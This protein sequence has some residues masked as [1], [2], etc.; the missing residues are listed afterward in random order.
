MASQNDSDVFSV[1]IVSLDYYMSSPIP[2]LDSCSSSFLGTNVEEVPVIRIYGATPAGQKTCVHVHGALPYFYVPFPKHLLQSSEEGQAFI[3]TLSGAM[4]KALRNKS[5]SSSKRQHVH[6][7]SL[8]RAKKLYGYH[9]SEDLF[10]KIFIYYP[11]DISRAASLLLDGSILGTS[12]QPYESHIPYLLQFLVDYNLNGMSHLHTSKVKFRSP[13]TYYCNAASSRNKNFDMPATLSSSDKTKIWLPSTVPSSAVW[14]DSTGSL[15]SIDNKCIDLIRRQSICQLE[16][17]TSVEDIINENFKIYTSLSQTSFDVRMVQSLVPI[18]EEEYERSGIHEATKLDDPKRPRADQVLRSFMDGLNYDKPL[19]ELCLE[20]SNFFPSKVHVDGSENVVKYMKPF[21]DIFTKIELAGSHQHDKSRDVCLVGGEEENRNKET[22]SSQSPMRGDLQRLDTEALGLLSWLAS[23]QAEEEMDTGDEL[24]HEAILSPLL[25]GKSYTAALEIAH[26]DYEHASQVECQDILDSVEDILKSERPKEEASTSFQGLILDSVECILMSDGSKE[27]ALSSSR[28][29]LDAVSSGVSIP[30]VDGSFDDNWKTP[31]KGNT[32]EANMSYGEDKAVARSAG[33]G[34]RAGSKNKERKLWGNLPFS[35]SKNEHEASESFCVSSSSCDEMINDGSYNPPF[36]HKEGNQYDDF[37]NENVIENYSEKSGKTSGLC[38]IRDLMRKKRYIRV[39]QVE[40]TVQKNEDMAHGQKQEL[41]PQFPVEEPSI[42]QSVTH[43]NIRGSIACSTIASSNFQGIECFEHH[44]SVFNTVQK[45][46]SPICTGNVQSSTAPSEIIGFKQGLGLNEQS[47][48]SE[49]A[50]NIEAGEL[51]VLETVP[52]QLLESS[53]VKPVGS[54]SYVKRPLSPP[55]IRKCQ[56]NHNENSAGNAAL[57]SHRHKNWN[58]GNIANNYAITSEGGIAQEALLP[59]MCHRNCQQSTCLFD[60]NSR[61]F[62]KEK[63]FQ[64]YIEMAFINRPPSNMHIYEPEESLPAGQANGNIDKRQGMENI[65]PF[66]PRISQDVNLY[67]E[68]VIFSQDFALGIPTHF[69]N[70]G[71]VL[72]LLTHAQS[73]PTLNTVYDW[74]LEEK[75]RCLLE[76]TGASKEGLDSYYDG[77]LNEGTTSCQNSPSPSASGWSQYDSTQSNK[78]KSFPKTENFHPDIGHFSCE[79]K[80]NNIPAKEKVVNEDLRDLSQISGPEKYG[81]SNPTPIS[82]LGFRDPASVGH[83]QQLTMISME[84]QAE[85]RGDLKPNPKFDAINILSLVVREDTSNVCQ[86]YVLLRVI[87]EKLVE[88]NGNGVS[89]CNLFFFTEE[90]LLLEHFVEIISYFDPDVLMGWEIQVGSLGYLA[91]RASYLGMKLLKKLSRTPFHE[92]RDKLEDSGH[93]K[94]SDVHPGVIENS[95]I[96]D[97]WGRTHASGLHVGGRIVLNIWRLMRA[98]LKLN[99]YTAEA[100]AEV[101]LRQKIPLFSHRKL[102]QWYSS[103][104]GRARDKCIGYVMERAM[105]NHK[106][107]D[108]LDMINRTSELA[109]IFGIDFFSVISRGS[110]FRVESMLLR[111]AHTQNYLAISPGYQ[112]VASQPAM[113]CL[114]LVMEPES[115]FYVDP[116]VVLDF[117]SLYPSMII[118]YNLC[119]CTCLG[120]AISSRGNVLGVSSYSPDV[121]ILKDLKEK[122]MLTPNGVMFVPPEVRKGVLPRL[123]EEILSTRIMV[124]QAMKKLKSSQLVLHRILN[125][126]QLALKLI[127]N[128]TYGYTA[129]GFS[130]RMPCAEIADSIVQCGRRTLETA[131]SFVNQHEKWKAKVIYGDTDSMFVLLKGRSKEDAFIIGNE[132][133][134]AITTMNPEPVA[135]KMEKVYQPCFLLTKKR[136][137]GYSYES[138]EQE[139]PTFDAKGIETVRRDTCPAVAKTLERSIRLIFESNDL[140]EVKSYLKRQWTRILA[141]KISLKDFVFAKEVRLGT[142]S[143]R[144]SSLPPAAIV[145]KKAMEMDPR[146]EPHYGERVPYVVVHGEPG[147]RLMDM[148]VNPS[149]LL[150]LNSPY[151]LNDLYYINKQMIPALQRVFGLLGADVNKWFS[152]I[153]RPTRPILAKRH[154]LMSHAQSFHED[155]S[156]NSMVSKKPNA[157]RMRIDTYYSSK[158]CIL[159]GDLIQSLEHFCV[160]CS[161]KK[162]LLAATVVG[163]TSKKE[164]EVLHLAEICRHCGGGDWIV[165]S[166]VKCISLSCAVF[167][168]RKKVQKEL[169]SL[170][171]FATASGFYPPC[172]ADELF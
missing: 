116:V 148:V 26:R 71:S 150:D 104:I 114:P 117:Q 57:K 106:I 140:S 67:D 101:V 99:M 17:D 77:M 118:A 138:P 89:V 53:E 64:E 167:Y 69:Q 21:S 157:K 87:D 156:D 166:G 61:D 121:Q 38:S 169:Q 95:I 100:V 137:V 96:E 108:Q 9:S 4:E 49:A 90:K 91:E 113:E 144:S 102:N 22:S 133:A 84:I 115:G 31:Q 2:D 171:S 154:T 32:S 158:H 98:E 142:Y 33:M 97:E 30:Q 172:D 146:A 34:L 130:G 135:L 134:S 85:S 11:H 132:I 50:L 12:F 29:L 19:H 70:D 149:D 46:F 65:M 44:S 170:S 111:L 152:A 54:V 73:P 153:P 62:C 103:G 151:R 59:E 3:H 8:V 76:A 161:R 63:N 81:N 24:L 14:P 23:S 105:I 83:G 131:I 124:K 10:V 127:S 93:S 155:D 147:S 119:F 47:K 15:D 51:S 123:L 58:S 52:M 40:T 159:C 160:K 88:K 163:R 86:S 107:M 39:E 66:F 13:L 79:P 25:P 109:R 126:R 80:L 75:Q 162:A 139:K 6:G 74:L 55:N 72:Y 42:G 165:E 78:E 82:Q 122:L 168:E 128:V 1:R 120:N 112:Q 164:S 136:Y 37:K 141:G 68:N 129:A 94:L 143:S 27:Q 48:I 7:C 18:W 16:V 92:I 28:D 125:A 20:T 145:A 41:T 43:Q 35:S 36:Y 5:I 60:E 110:Q 45:A 56:S